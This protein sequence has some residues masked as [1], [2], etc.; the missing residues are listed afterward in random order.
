MED[1]SG[2]PGRAQQGREARRRLLD[3]AVAQL[4]DAGVRGL[5]HRKVEQRAGCAQGS[6]KYHFGSSDALIQAVLDHLAGRDLPLVLEI[7][8]AG[9]GPPEETGR[10]E[11]RAQE[12]AEAMLARPDDVRARFQIYL[13]AAGNA[14]LQ[15][16][17][18]AARDRFVHK[19]AESLPGPGS[20]AAAR[21]VCAVIDGIL[22]DQVSAPNPLVQDNAAR[23][24]LAAGSAG[25]VIANDPRPA[26]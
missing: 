8:A 12:A 7:P 23:Y 1:T 10:L 19:I 11:Q 4:A 9:E 15:G 13:Y 21:F 20:E 16:Q 25:N 5:T 26:G 22:L 6:I 2:H 17:V 14:R 3:A 24:L 18:A